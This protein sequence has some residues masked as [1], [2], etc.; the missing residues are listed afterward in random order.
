MPSLIDTEKKKFEFMITY[1]LKNLI[2]IKL[3]EKYL[4]L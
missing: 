1:K 2:I 3:F 4:E